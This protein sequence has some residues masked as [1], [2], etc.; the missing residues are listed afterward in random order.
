MSAVQVPRTVTKLYRRDVTEATKRTGTIINQVYILSLQYLAM[1]AS[2]D[3]D[4]KRMHAVNI[5]RHD[6]ERQRDSGIPSIISIYDMRPDIPLWWRWTA[7]LNLAIRLA[8]NV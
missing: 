7:G 4:A 3:P 8:H 1:L 2:T 5:Q 6:V